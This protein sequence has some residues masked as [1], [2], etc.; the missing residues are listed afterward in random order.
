MIALP[1][2]GLFVLFRPLQPVQ[3]YLVV[4]LHVSRLVS[5]RQVGWFELG[6][7]TTEV[8]IFLIAERDEPPSAFH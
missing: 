8:I 7:N 6:P 3:G 4:I 2:A 5:V 1:T